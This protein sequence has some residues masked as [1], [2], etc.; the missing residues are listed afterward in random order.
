M[1]GGKKT[2]IIISVFIL[3]IILN[4][5]LLGL[6]SDKKKALLRA[7]SALNEFNILADEYTQLN[8]RNAE[9]EKRARITNISGILAAVEETMSSVGLKEKL[10]SVK[11]SGR[12]RFTDYLE[13]RALVK[14]KSLSLKELVD[15]L[16]GFENAP[17]LFLIKSFAMKKKFSSTNEFSVTMDISFIKKEGV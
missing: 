17:M 12:E 2:V 11:L 15:I 13:E 9:F 4:I 10:T 6:L 7:E 5:S 8:S 16:H 14:C 3:L 1:F